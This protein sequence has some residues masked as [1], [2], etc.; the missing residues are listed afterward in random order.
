MSV[1]AE[2]RKRSSR[3]GVREEHQHEDEEGCDGA[4]DALQDGAEVLTARRGAT[5]QRERCGQGIEGRE[6]EQRRLAAE[7]GDEEEAG[8]DRPDEATDR[9][10]REELRRA[11]ARLRAL[12]DHRPGRRKARAERQREGEEQRERDGADD[13]RLVR[14]GVLLVRED[15]DEPRRERHERHRERREHDEQRL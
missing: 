4:A 10:G 13:P 7:R 5:A 1:E 3:L 9:V 6:R 15:R 8:R 11:L 14:H 2:R 12:L